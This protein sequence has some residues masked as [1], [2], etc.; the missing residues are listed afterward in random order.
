MLWFQLIYL[1]VVWGFSIYSKILNV[2]FDSGTIFLSAAF[3]IL[4]FSLP[5][6]QEKKYLFQIA[7]FLLNGFVFLTFYS[8]VF[9]GFILLIFL[10][11]ANQFINKIKGIRLYIHLFIQYSIIVSPYIISY[12]LRMLVYIHLLLLLI[13]WGTITW[14]RTY[15][16][17]T[18]FLEEESKLQNDYRKLKRQAVI[19]EKNVRQEERNQIAREIHDSVGHRLTSLLMQLEVA[20]LESESSSEKEK[21]VRLKSLAK[22]SLDETR[23]AVK[24]LKGEETAGLTAVVQLIR[25]LEAESHLRISF[26]IKSGTLSSPLTNKQSVVLYRSVQEALT[27]MMK[28]SE[29]K[30]AE[31]EF[32]ILADSYFQFQISNPAKTKVNITEGFGLTAMKER[33]DEL[34]GSL[35]IIQ[36]EGEFQI[37]GAFPLEKGDS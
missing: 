11:V 12:D 7:I 37:K 21:F 20:R 6:L 14:T 16:K 33:L 36:A 35:K 32:R 18:T 10:I 1:I 25:K 15:S 9:N 29:T 26:S 24:A 34:G 23:K 30:Q 31:I 13:V 3:F 28:H 4:Y 19:H 5:L 17:Y 2:G 22:S 27:N 8:Y